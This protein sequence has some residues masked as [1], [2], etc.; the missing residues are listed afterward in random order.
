MRNTNWAA[1]FE[2]AQ[3]LFESLKLK[4]VLRMPPASYFF[5]I[6]GT[7]NR[8]DHIFLNKELYDGV[9]MEVMPETFRIIAPEFASRAFEF[10]SS[11]HHFYSSVI[12]GIPKRYNHDTKNA[13]VAGYSDHFPVSVK[14]K[15]N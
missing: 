13:A 11:D 12:F 5:A 10:Y 3:V 8:L 9:G 15:M 4:Q 6:E 1:K 2:D 14:L 7:W